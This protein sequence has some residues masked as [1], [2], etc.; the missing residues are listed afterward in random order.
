MIATQLVDTVYPGMWIE[1]VPGSRS[2]VAVLSIKSV[3]TGTEVEYRE[4]EG[5]E[6]IAT[7]PPNATVLVKS[8]KRGRKIARVG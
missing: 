6:G 8:G 5:G 7:F 3:A 2:F 1:V 4:P